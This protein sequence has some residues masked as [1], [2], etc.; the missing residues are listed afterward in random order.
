VSL[1]D[2]APLCLSMNPSTPLCVRF[3][4]GAVVCAN[5][6]LEFGDIAAQTRALFASINSALTPLNPF[7]DV[8]DVVVAV[9]QCVQAVPD[10]IGPPPDPT[11]IEECIPNLIQKV[12]TLL[13]MLPAYSVPIMIKDI[14]AA[15]AAILLGLKL[16][17][18]AFLSQESRIIAAAT[19]AADSPMLAAVLDC[20]TQN[21]SIG[22]ANLGAANQPLN[23]LI[24]DVNA[25]GQLV[26]LPPL[27]MMTDLGS[28]AATA[29][30]GI[31]PVI[32]IL[33]DIAAAIPG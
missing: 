4:G 32:T 28:D 25:F 5:I 30:A 27:P 12:A 21:L 8:I 10:L 13:E 14:C 3:P 33:Q 22:L 18:T 16:E 17:L 2:L 23:R 26:G 6:G 19:A 29:L 11:K 20:A 15:L 9:L 24:G 31:D 1:P 7:F